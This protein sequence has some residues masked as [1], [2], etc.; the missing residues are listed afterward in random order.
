MLLANAP[1]IILSAKTILSFV[2]C[3]FKPAELVL[4]DHRLRQNSPV[5][6]DRDKHF[7]GLQIIGG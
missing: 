6:T 1:L 7:A 4:P 5:Q 3:F 2:L